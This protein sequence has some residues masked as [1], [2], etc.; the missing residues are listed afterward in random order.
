MSREIA[1]VRCPQGP[2]NLLM[3]L[4][5]DSEA[6]KPHITDENLIEIFCR[7][8]TRRARRE[9]GSAGLTTSF[10]I[11]HRFDFM[12]DFIESVREPVE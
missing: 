6:P 2:R 10:R 8:C 3:K 7:D 9:M 12:G 1:E 4:R 11:I 5:V